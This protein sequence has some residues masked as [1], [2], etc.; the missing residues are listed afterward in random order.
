[1]LRQTSYFQT[2]KDIFGKTW[3]SY[4]CRSSRATDDKIFFFINSLVMDLSN[5]ISWSPVE[6]EL[7]Q[8]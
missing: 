3:D 1:M 4:A 8:H 7:Q 2:S 6:Y 5:S